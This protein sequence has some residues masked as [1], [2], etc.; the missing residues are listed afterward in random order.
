MLRY[1]PT[2]VVVG[3]LVYCLID[4]VQAPSEVVRALPKPVWLL[5]IL[6]L[7]LLGSVAW[8]LAGRPDGQ[9]RRGGPPPPRRPQGPDDDPDFLR[10]LGRGPSR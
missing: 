2:L 10:R 5:V 8:L 7:P 6:L 9:G 3:L 4:C 1:L